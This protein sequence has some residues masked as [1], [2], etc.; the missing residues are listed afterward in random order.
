[1][2]H[3]LKEFKIETSKADVDIIAMMERSESFWTLVQIDEPAEE[4]QHFLD[5]LEPSIGGLIRKTIPNAPPHQSVTFMMEKGA[6]IDLPSSAMLKR[7]SVAMGGAAHPESQL[8]D[9][10]IS[11]VLFDKGG[12]KIAA[13]DGEHPDLC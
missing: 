13:V 6:V 9:L 10:D 11:A 1:M 12:R 2:G 5:I 7:I 3:T 4:G 8:V